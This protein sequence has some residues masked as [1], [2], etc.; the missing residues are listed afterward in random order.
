MRNGLAIAG[1]LGL[2]LLGASPSLAKVTTVR[3]Q[4]EAR[5]G[6]IITAELAKDWTALEAILAPDYRSIDTDGTGVSR[7]TEI[8]QNKADPT[9]ASEQ[10][11]ITVLS[12]KLDGDRAYVEQRLD[13]RFT[14]TGDD[15]QRH[16]YIVVS[17]SSDI[18]RWSS[19]NWVCVQSVTNET[20][21][22][23]DGKPWLYDVA[24]PVVA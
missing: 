22:V 9:D 3:A 16:R 7:A 24:H 1:A 11:R 2:V 23:M 19:G 5:Y 12:L 21:I 20:G 18:W 14:L 10:D 4:L 15:G 6:E 13:A 17:L 8:A